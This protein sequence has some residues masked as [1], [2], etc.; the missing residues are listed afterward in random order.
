MITDSLA[1]RLLHPPHVR[2]LPF[3]QS[4]GFSLAYLASLACLVCH[5]CQLLAVGVCIFLSSASLE[6]SN[7]LP[8]G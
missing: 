5:G 2:A 1:G 6:N 7:D 4:F 8:P 3:G